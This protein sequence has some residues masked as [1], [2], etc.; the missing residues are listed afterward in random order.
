[1]NKFE[2][3]LKGYINDEGEEQGERFVGVGF[4][5]WLGGVIG[6]G[7]GL[8]LGAC[9]CGRSSTISTSHKIQLVVAVLC[10]TSWVMVFLQ[11]GL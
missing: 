5:D 11:G 4:I 10:G 2:Q 7:L 8:G 3:A 1:M 6:I 9:V